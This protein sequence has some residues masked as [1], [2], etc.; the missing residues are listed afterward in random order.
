MITTKQIK[1]LNPAN[2]WNE[3]IPLGNGFAGVM[4]DGK[5]EKDTIYLN[6]DS[7]WYGGY[8]DRNNKDAYSNLNEIRKLIFE[9][10]LDEACELSMMSLC[11]IP[12]SQRNYASAGT[13]NIITKHDNVHNYSRQLDLSTATAKTNYEFEGITFEREYFVSNPSNIIAVKL[14]S[15]SENAVSFLFDFGKE[16]NVDNV[17]YDGTDT[18]IRR[19]YSGGE[20]GIT[21]FQAVKIVADGG[22]FESIGQNIRIKN[23][24]TAVIYIAQGT[25][26]RHEN[27]KKYC[28]GLLENASKIGYEELLNEHVKDYKSLFDKL[29]L[30]LKS[31]LDYES[32]TELFD[33]LTVE[34]SSALIETYFNFGRYLLI[35]CSR[36]GSL[37][38]NLQGVWCNDYFPIW[39]SKFT[40]NINTQMNYWPAELL[41]L[42][43]CHL[44]LFELIKKIAVNG[45]VTAKQMYNARGFCCHH[46][47]DIWA[48][49]AAQDRNPSATIWALG[50]AW[51]CTHIVDRYNFTK[52]KTFA[53]DNFYL[54]K[55]ACEFVLDYQ[56]MHENAYVTNPSSSPENT[57][58]L[59]SGQKAQLTYSCAMDTQLIITL[60]TGTITVANELGI[61]AG[62][63]KV[64]EERIAQMPKPVQIS[65]SGRVMEWIKD[66]EEVDK[67][68]R[69]ISHLFALYPSNI[70]GDNREM[71]AAARKTLE[72]RLSSG[73]GH[74]GWS[75]AW[76]INMWA[77]LRDGEKFVEAFTK[78]LQNST[79]PNLFDKHPPF[80]I[81]GNFG[82]I[83]GL[84]EALVQSH[85]EYIELLPALPKSWKNGSVKGICLRGNFEIDITWENNRLKSAEIRN[86]NSEV[87]KIRVK[88]N[89]A[90]TNYTIEA[91]QKKDLYL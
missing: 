73:G 46:N 58:Y 13:V 43:S 10:K 11:G 2:D 19:S 80:Q 39:D 66:Y 60:F 38:A 88:N 59:E 77:R 52:D 4:F 27:P 21:L 14:S 15:N 16:R 71:L 82:S 70:I 65:K 86:K 90:I 1:Y 63:T 51:L 54:L 47:T 78:L 91:Y 28:L 37:P 48:D 76:I 32:T 5:T 29:S 22:R 23:A 34:N 7:F 25:T 79:Y 72:T 24:K 55:S 68:H 44:P 33:K 53:L 62:F 61:E 36:E 56:I 69:H 20:N 18:V 17:E 64:L 75:M 40:V 49:T 83:A 26:Y 67:G 42:S 3:C 30:D 57:F 8:R 41:N 45:E 87:K 85:N 12:E 50:A 9:E 89:G 84:G 35:S 31:D 81:D 74:T 6:E